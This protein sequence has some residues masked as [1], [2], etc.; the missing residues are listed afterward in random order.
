MTADAT[1]I[2]QLKNSQLH[3]VRR[4]HFLRW[5]RNTHG[6]LGLW[7]AGL[8]LLFGGTGILLNHRQVLKLPYV[9]YEKTNIDLKLPAQKPASAKALSAWLQAELNI[10]RAPLKIE[11][12]PAKKVTWN[13]IQVEQPAVWKVDFHS[14]EYSVTAE[15]LV[16][17][18]FVSIKRQD[19]NAFAFLSRLHKGVGMNV[20]WILLI[21]SLA[22]ALMM[23]S[24][25]GVLL[26]T[27]MRKS[28]LVAAVLIGT[29]TLLAVGL[30]LS[31]M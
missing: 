13:S 2:S 26:W 3:R 24:M 12:E 18:A 9:Q 30:T 4:G 8:G 28:R 10:K 25:T 15:Y 6:W 7:G 23:L 16:G 27:K 5:L 21:D 20:G 17:N 11:D 31:M 14:P 19:A 29:S 1:L 22:G